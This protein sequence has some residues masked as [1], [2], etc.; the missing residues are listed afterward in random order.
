MELNQWIHLS[1]M[2]LEVKQATARLL[3]RS[4]FITVA[5]NVNRNKHMNTHTFTLIEGRFY[6]RLPGA[7]AFASIILRTT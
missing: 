3:P 7:P 6:I 5:V 4:I 1:V 2:G